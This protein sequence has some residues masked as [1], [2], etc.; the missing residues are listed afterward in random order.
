MQVYVVKK[1]RDS[2]YSSGTECKSEINEMGD[3]NNVKI[4]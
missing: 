4:K 1:E 2:S 3:F